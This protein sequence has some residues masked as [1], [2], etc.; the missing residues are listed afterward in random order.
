M[1]LLPNDMCYS[2]Q[3]FAANRVKNEKVKTE[4]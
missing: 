2:L 1:I 4:S 3:S